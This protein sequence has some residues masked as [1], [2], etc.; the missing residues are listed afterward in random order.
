MGRG[1]RK[2]SQHLMPR[3]QS[4]LKSTLV[5]TTA[6]R[7]IIG[8]PNIILGTVQRQEWILEMSP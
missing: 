4:K 1:C 3:G 5:A 6:L 2:A 8:C 7:G